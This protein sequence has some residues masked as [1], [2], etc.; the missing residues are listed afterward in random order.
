MKCAIKT[1][2]RN[3]LG[4]LRVSV[5]VYTICIQILWRIVYTELRL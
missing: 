3:P 2:D 5:F 4:Q 1:I